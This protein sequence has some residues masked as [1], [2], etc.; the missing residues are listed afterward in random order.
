[1]TLVHSL[2]FISFSVIVLSTVTASFSHSD[3]YDETDDPTGICKFTRSADLER[4][5]S[6]VLS[7]VVSRAELGNDKFYRIARDISFQNGDWMQEPKGSPLMPFDD[8]DMPNNNG[9][10]FE[11]LLKLASFYLTGIDFAHQTDTTVG[12]CGLL[13]IGITR[14]RT[15]SYSPQKWSPWFHKSPGYSDLTIVFEGLYAESQE[16]G[17]RLMCLLG[18]SLFPYSDIYSNSY[19]I[20]SNIIVAK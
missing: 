13:S 3:N 19:D 17:E 7:S 18:T 11:S 4:E 9:S 20:G 15:M 5:C 12:L 1:M 14:N 8:T 2:L 10:A 16:T 6:P